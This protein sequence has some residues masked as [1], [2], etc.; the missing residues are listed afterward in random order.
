MPNQAAI[1]SARARVTTLQAEF[2]SP[3]TTRLGSAAVACVQ[4]SLDDAE[5]HL[6]VLEQEAAARAVVLRE[7][8]ALEGYR[9]IPAPSGLGWVVQ[10]WA[11]GVESIGAKGGSELEALESALLL[12][13]SAADRA[14]DIEAA[15]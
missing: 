2:A 1:K 12:L 11:R 13:P 10:P 4:R 3:E 8:L 14:A 6:A 7:A 5:Y 15:A 9:C